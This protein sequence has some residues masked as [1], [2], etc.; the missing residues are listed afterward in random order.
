MRI[1][2]IMKLMMSNIIITYY[3]IEKIEYIKLLKCGDFWIY[4]SYKQRN[5]NILM[6]L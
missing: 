6:V 1:C 5:A 2:V 4:K 3:V